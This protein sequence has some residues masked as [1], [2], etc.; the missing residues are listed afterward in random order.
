MPAI[1]TMILNS[2]I[3][4]GEK[5]I[6]VSSLT[7]AEQNYHLSRLNSMMDSWSQERLMVHQLSQTSFALTASQ[8]SYSIGGGG[9]FNMTRPTRIV[10]PCFIRDSDGTDT[11]LQ[12]LDAIAYGRIVDK[13]VDE[14]Y[15]AYLFYDYGYSATSTA[16]LRLWPEPAAGLILFINTLQPLQAFSTMSVALSLP[17]G[18]QDAIEL[19]YAVRSALGVIP[20]SSELK[21]AARAAKAAIKGTN[22]PAPVARLDYG[23]TGI[24]GG[25]GRSI[26]TGP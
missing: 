22:L 21:L 10:D 7:T 4:T 19:N 11:E 16:T 26:L 5:T 23:V 6:Q 14:T 20:V 1:S 18:Y 2:L 15:P 9:N 8:G 25:S 24:S 17:P 12:I 13:D 3:M